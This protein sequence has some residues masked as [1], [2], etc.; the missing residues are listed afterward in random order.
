VPEQE[1]VVGDDGRMVKPSLWLMTLPVGALAALSLLIGVFAEPLM[2]VMNLIGDQL[3]HPEGYIHA[4]MGGGVD[5]SEALIE[6]P[7]SEEGTP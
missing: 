5:V 2:L 4:V 1:T 6:A 7:A 3:M